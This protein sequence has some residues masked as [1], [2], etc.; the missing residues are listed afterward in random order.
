VVGK[1]NTQ[2]VRK[3]LVLDELPNGVDDEYD[4]AMA[5]IDQ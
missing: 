3:A 4:E 2:A 1:I 5:R